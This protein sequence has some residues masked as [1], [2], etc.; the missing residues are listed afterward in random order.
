MALA[1]AARLPAVLR[2]R[3]YDAV[4]VHRAV[5]LAGPAVLERVLAAGGPPLVFDFD[6]AIWLRHTSGANAL[7]DRLKFPG[8]TATLCRLADR[9]VVGSD[10]LAGWAR[11][12][13]A[14]VD[15]VPTSIDTA[16]Y[17]VRDRPPGDARGRRLDGQRDL[18]D[19]PGGR[20]RRCCARLAAARP[21]EIRVLSTRTPVLPDVPVTFRHWTPENEVEEIRA[22]D[23][24]I[25]PMPDDEWARGKCPMKELQYLA[26]RV[27][28]VCSA[29][30]GSREA[31]RH[32][33]NGFLVSTRGRVDGGA[34]ASRGR[35]RAAG[36]P[37][38]GRAP[39]R[40]GALRFRAERRRVRRVGARGGGAEMTDSDTEAVRQHSREAESFTA[41]YDQLGQD[42]YASCFA[43]SRRRLDLLLARLL[44][45]QPARPDLLD[46]GC[47]TG[48]HLK[49]LRA[50]GYD[51]VGVDGSGAML[52]EAR[53][54]DA[55]GSARAVG[56][57]GAAVPVGV[58]RRGALGRG[59][60]LPAGPAAAPARD[61]ARAAA[62]RR[63]LRDRRALAEPQRL[64]AS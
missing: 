6:D 4:L 19:A 8:K 49:A 30:G 42:P 27:P 21:V 53:G 29:V 13:S 55:L 63:L 57:D 43:Y 36:A 16:A 51:A 39:H 41:G 52:R 61:R 37:G 44:P 14:R 35:S 38:R 22:F 54:L 20:A 24:G 7:F 64:S 33:D 5:C 23:I 62:R 1:T 26:L 25:K 50:R 59:P 45:A 58:V 28:A 60:S 48:H 40:A 34:A 10:Y 3:R 47:G 56:R 31:V 2:A 15:V 12:H 17:E 18:D 32:G 11:Q 46:V 9:V